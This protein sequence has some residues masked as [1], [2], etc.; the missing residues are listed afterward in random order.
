MGN[1]NQRK[2]FV[3]LFLDVF[4]NP[5]I[6][7]FIIGVVVFLLFALLMHFK[8]LD[9]FE[10]I[11]LEWRF[12]SFHS[13][14]QASDKCIVLAIDKK[15]VEEFG[16]GQWSRGIYAE[17]VEA[18]EFYG[19]KSVAFDVF[20]PF[21][22][23]RDLDGDAK[24]AQVVGKYDNIVMASSI[25]NELKTP[26]TE[27]IARQLSRFSLADS[28]GLKNIP[29]EDVYSNIL[30]KEDLER[31]DIFIMPL[32]PYKDLFDVVKSIGIICFGSKDSGKS[33]KIFQ[34]PLVFGFE[35]QSFPVLSLESYLLTLESKAIK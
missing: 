9:S 19:V 23:K 16:T 20:F 1:N 8:A 29:V 35:K 32:A 4:N 15:S 28:D 12:K 11:T 6:M 26:E 3:N 18:L 21:K 27:K 34:I 33:S 17:L 5:K 13:Q 2:S 10:L 30:S 31:K 7:S 14:A 22:N 24:F 25:E